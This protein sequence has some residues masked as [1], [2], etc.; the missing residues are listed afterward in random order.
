MVHGL[1]VLLAIIF[2]E[3][4][5]LRNKEIEAKWSRIAAGRESFLPDVANA[6]A[7]QCEGQI[8]H[9]RIPCRRGSLVL[10]D[11]WLASGETDHAPGKQFSW[12]YSQSR[13]SEDTDICRHEPFGL[14]SK[15]LRDCSSCA[16]TLHHAR[17]SC[18]HNRPGDCLESAGKCRGFDSEWRS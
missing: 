2:H 18:I 4:S 9:Q 3:E 15:T 16:Q 10:E 12:E 1:E 11:A 13:M 7:I 6:Y 5:E 14:V 17:T 8:V